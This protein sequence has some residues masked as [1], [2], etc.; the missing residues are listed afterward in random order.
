VVGLGW[1]G[2][3]ILVLPL[4][5]ALAVEQPFYSLGPF[6]DNWQL[7]VGIAVIGAV[8]IALAFGHLFLLM[9]S[10][11]RAADHG[12]GTLTILEVASDSGRDTGFLIQGK[13]HFAGLD[14]EHQQRVVRAR[15]LGA[16]LMLLGALWLVVGFGLAILLAARG[17][18][19]PSGIWLMSLAPTGVIAAVGAF[20]LIVQNSTVRGLQTEWNAQEG[21]GQLPRLD[22]G[23]ATSLSWCSNTDSRSK[24]SRSH[25]PDTSWRHG[26][27]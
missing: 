16:A 19:T 23:S 12:Y 5:W 22:R 14:D 8:L 25:H 9:R 27:D 2:S 1:T 4:L 21:S 10:A 26:R 15:L 6:E 7:G 24:A 3:V 13:R 17:F 20:F 11:A 18:V